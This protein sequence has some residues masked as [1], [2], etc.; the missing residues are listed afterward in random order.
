MIKAMSNVQYYRDVHLC[1]CRTWKWSQRLLQVARRT[2]G[3]GLLVLVGCVALPS[4]SARLSIIAFAQVPYARNLCGRNPQ[5][6]IIV[7]VH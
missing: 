7:P 1:T 3:L 5:P 6:E 4:D 2:R